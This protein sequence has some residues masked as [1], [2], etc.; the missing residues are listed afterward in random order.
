M[1]L[2]GQAMLLFSIWVSPCSLSHYKFYLDPF[3]ILLMLLSPSSV[4]HILSYF[5][6]WTYSHIHTHLT[7][8]PFLPCSLS[9]VLPILSSFPVKFLL[10]FPQAFFFLALLLK[11]TLIFFIFFSLLWIWLAFCKCLWILKNGQQSKPNLKLEAHG[12]VP[13]RF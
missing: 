12:S 6:S 9:F 7:T 4:S 5:S 3:A 10:A 8:S 13:Q 2:P 11:E 1:L